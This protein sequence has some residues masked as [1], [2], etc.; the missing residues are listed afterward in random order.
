VFFSEFQ[1][2]PPYTLDEIIIRLYLLSFFDG[3]HVDVALKI[4]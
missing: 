3:W 1:D 2:G 4:D